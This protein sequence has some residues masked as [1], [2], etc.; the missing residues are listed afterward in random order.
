MFIANVFNGD[1]GLFKC[2][3][4]ITLKTKIKLISFELFPFISII[5]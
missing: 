4:N 1:I 5:R 2:L 3:L